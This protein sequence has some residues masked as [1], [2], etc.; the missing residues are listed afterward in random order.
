LNADRLEEPARGHVLVVD[1]DRDL[2][3]T[4]RELLEFEG[5]DV[6]TAKHGE[7]AL[8]WLRSSALPDVILLDLSMPVMDGAT[9]RAHQQQDVAL[10]AIPVVV[11]S[12]SGDLAEKARAL[13]PEDMLSKPVALAT[14]LAII[15]KHCARRG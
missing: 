14:L 12:A 8:A 9:F 2:R 6:A 1:D 7:E 3:E 13:A 5:Y 15:D 11:L 10:K 4:L